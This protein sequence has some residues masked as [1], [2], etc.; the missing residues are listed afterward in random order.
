MEVAFILLSL[1]TNTPLSREPQPERTL[2]ALAAYVRT[3]SVK[4]GLRA[5]RQLVCRQLRYLMAASLFMGSPL[6]T[7]RASVEVCDLPPNQPAFMPRPLTLKVSMPAHTRAIVFTMGLSPCPCRAA[8]SCSALSEALGVLFR[9]MRTRSHKW[10]RFDL[11]TV[12]ESKRCAKLSPG[13]M[14]VD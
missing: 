3:V 13:S 11:S 7:W 1:L 9:V 8:A 4:K 14:K 10:N 2:H 6:W 5:S 12:R